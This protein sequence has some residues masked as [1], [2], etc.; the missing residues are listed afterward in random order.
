MFILLFVLMAS[1]EVNTFDRDKRQIIAKDHLRAQTRGLQAFSITGFSE[2]TLQN[3]ADTLI[4]NP[5]G[6]ILDFVYKDSAGN[7]LEKKATV[8]FAP[9]SFTVLKTEITDKPLTSQ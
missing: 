8:I 1:C 4:K 2:D 3:F 6:Y 5:L 9:G 7:I